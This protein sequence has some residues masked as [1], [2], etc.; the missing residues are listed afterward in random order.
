M[1]NIVI[2]G[3][4]RSGTSL[5]LL[6][7]AQ[8]PQALLGNEWLNTDLEQVDPVSYERKINGVI[9]NLFKVFA[10]QYQHPE[11]I[12]IVQ[13][14]FTVGITRLNKAAQE[15]SF[16][17]ACLTG[18][19]VKTHE[20]GKYKYD[21]VPHFSEWVVLGDAFANMCRVT[22]TYEHIVENWDA[23]IEEILTEAGWPV[24]QLPMAIEKQ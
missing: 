15:A 17:K 6:S 2:V 3:S 1:K 14:S 13:N 19:W 10:Y 18:Q 5:L 4:P 11:F 22:Y 16:H 8:H 21:Y 24:M 12:G 7:L 23:V 20:L 9:C